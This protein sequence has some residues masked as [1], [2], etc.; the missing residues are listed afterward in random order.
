[1]RPPC[2]GRAGRAAVA[3]GRRGRHRRAG[4]AAAHPRVPRTDGHRGERHGRA[5]AH[6]RRVRCL[7]RCAGAS[8]GGAGRRPARGGA[9]GAG[10]RHRARPHRRHPHRQR[11]DRHRPRRS[12]VAGRAVVP[13]R[14]VRGRAGAGPA[15]SGRRAARRPRGRRARAAAGAGPDP[16]RRARDPPWRLRRHAARRRD[17]RRGGRR[18]ADRPGG[19][20]AGAV[21]GRAARPGAGGGRPAARPTSPGGALMS[22]L[23]GLFPLGTTLL[24]GQLLPLHVFEPRYRELVADLV[25]GSFAPGAGAT[26]RGP[27]FGVVAIRSG[28]E[29]GT[30]AVPRLHG[31]GCVAELLEVQQH[32][33]GSS[34]LVAVGRERFQLLGLDAGAGNSYLTGRVSWLE[35]P[36]GPTP[37]GLVAEVRELFAG[38]RAA[39]TGAGVGLETDASDAERADSEEA[40][41][42]APEGPDAGLRRADGGGPAAS[43]R[44]PKDPTV[45]S[46][47]VAGSMVL[48]V[49]ERQALLE[50]LDAARRLARLR[51]LLRRELT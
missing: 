49:G 42:P 37:P 18:P 12:P 34:D 21:G 28:S 47:A 41:E 40:D 30:D 38:Y 6:A 2:C 51:R 3:R 22:D 24:P 19:P 25:S 32:R 44:L 17:P 15:P 33:D 9:A 23:L 1:M 7:V 16:Y 31:V 26:G 20:A 8:R 4:V 39:L 36:L 27:R 29:V 10:D 43:E 46:W 48:H 35:E 45:L 14:G 11:D 50:D 5:P 13:A